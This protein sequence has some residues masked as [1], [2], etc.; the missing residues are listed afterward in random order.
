MWAYAEMEKRPRRA[1]AIAPA[2]AKPSRPRRDCRSVWILIT[3]PS[4]IHCHPAHPSSAPFA[5]AI[6]CPAESQ[7]SGHI[8]WGQYTCRLALHIESVVAAH[9]SAD[10][11]AVE[12][13]DGLL[14]DACFS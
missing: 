14:K 1:S 6:T 13:W 9:R 12:R 7:E 3:A 8:D 5:K 10:T 2:L 11:T 4:F